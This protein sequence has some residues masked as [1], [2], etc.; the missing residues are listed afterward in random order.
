MITEK[1]ME[2]YPSIKQIIYYFQELDKIPRGSKN[3]EQVVKYLINFA[4]ERNLNYYTD[5]ANNIVI[6]KNSTDNSDYYLA[7][8]SHTDMVCEKM[9]DSNHNFSKDPID[10]K[11]DGD[12]IKSNETSIGADN[13]IGVAYM[14]TILDSNDLIHPNV[15][16]IFTSDE[17]GSMTGA[18]NIDLS[19]IKSK[20]IISLDAF[21]ENTIIYGCASNYSRV[22]VFSKKLEAFNSLGNTISIKIDGFL[23]GHSGIDIDKGRG[24]PIISI[25]TIINDL[26]KIDNDLVINNVD[27]G[28]WVTSIP[29]NA[30]CIITSSKL[31][32][33]MIE[34]LV[35]SYERLWKKEYN[36]NEITIQITNKKNEGKCFD[37]KTSRKIINYILNFPNGVLLRDEEKNV[38]LSTNLGTIFIDND[39]L[40]IENSI[41]SNLKRDETNI[42]IREIEKNDKENDF[43]TTQIFD[44]PGYKQ[45]KNSNFIIFL[46]DLYK[47]IYN[48]DPKLKQ[49][50]IFLEGSWFAKKIN[51]LEYVS[52]SPNIYYAHSAN[53]MVSLSS[54][55]KMWEYIKTTLENYDKVLSIE[56]EKTKCKKNTSY[57]CS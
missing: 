55:S 29:R 47:T 34:D 42:I 2:S 33:K 19:K 20:R 35:K 3:E 24:N 52:I 41:R 8:Q 18:K 28:T 32:I 1:E 36:N 45:E 13:G 48:K 50:H 11:I 51:N 43:I 15:E 44:F 5:D 54:I 25:A 31:N 37:S 46:S 30:E 4:K 26:Q 27:S 16:M 23:G 6:F 9:V 40:I 53:E 7:F 12:Y 57:N 21:N 22:L 56:K 10:L 49:E 14:L 17:E 38:I 39:N